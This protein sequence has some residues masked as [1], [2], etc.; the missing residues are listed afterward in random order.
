[1]EFDEEIIGCGGWSRRKTLFGASEYEMSR[2]DSMLNPSIDAAKIRAFFVH[3]KAAR[4]GVG[5]AILDLCEAAAV[6]EG[7]TAAEMMAT[8]PGVPLYT[9]RGYKEI[10]E[11]DVPLPD[12]GESIACIRMR[13]DL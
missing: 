6:A 10:E 4:Q 1:V 2:D 7:F 11:V 3:P 9:V 13:K 12:N 8:L 5:T